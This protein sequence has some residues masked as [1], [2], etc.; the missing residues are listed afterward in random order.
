M[1]NEGTKIRAKAT[2]WVLAALYL[3]AIHILVL[4]A[5]FQPHL[6]DEQR[7]RSLQLQSEP[8][9]FVSEMHRVLRTLDRDAPVGRVI[10]LGDSQFQR[11]DGSL[12]P[13]PMLNL[14]IGQDTIRN[15]HGRLEDYRSIDQARV[16]IIW[17]GVNDLLRG[18]DSDQIAT[19][20]KTLLAKAEKVDRIILLSI[21]QLAEDFDGPITSQAIASLNKMLAQTCSGNCTFLDLSRDLSDQK[22]HLRPDFD[23]GDGLHLNRAGHALVAER[24][25]TTLAEPA[26]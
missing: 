4:V 23:F 8:N 13:F 24:I 5:L 11:M 10:L 12:L 14:A 6:I 20:M 17:G 21:P 26:L 1:E 15:M 2:W 7:W 19:D 25:A 16:L 18:R 22:G 9:P 3:I